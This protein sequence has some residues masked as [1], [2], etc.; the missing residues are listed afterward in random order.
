MLTS[1]S[2]GASTTGEL[3]TI[4]RVSVLHRAPL[5]AEV[6]GHALVAVARLLE[7]VHV[8]AG[9]TVIE[10]GA[11]EDWLFV[12]AAGSVRVH[13]GDR[14][15]AVVDAGGVVG[16]LA[17]LAPAPRAASATAVEATLLLRLRRGPF[18]EL[19]EDRPEIARAVIHTLARLLQAADHGPESTD[20]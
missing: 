20:A 14:T 18:E 2:G 3:M 12:V 5:F 15:L 10:R 16:E 6:P 19:L 13:V 4:E 8:D 7:E 1:V 11:L 17:V 9:A